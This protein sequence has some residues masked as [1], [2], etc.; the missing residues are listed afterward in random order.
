MGV[1]DDDEPA[2]IPPRQYYAQLEAEEELSQYKRQIDDELRLIEKKLELLRFQE[3]KTG[4]LPEEGDEAGGL[5]EDGFEEDGNDFLEEQGRLDSLEVER[6]LRQEAEADQEEREIYEAMCRDEAK[7]S[8]REQ[9][10]LSNIQRV[11][12]DF[13]H[14]DFEQDGNLFAASAQQKDSALQRE[15]FTRRLERAHDASPLSG[16]AKAAEAMLAA[17]ARS[18]LLSDTDRFLLDAL[19]KKFKK[20][21]SS[22]AAAPVA[23]AGHA[24]SE[25]RR[26]LTR[27]SSALCRTVSAE[28][29]ALVTELPLFFVCALNHVERVYRHHPARFRIVDGEMHDEKAML[30]HYRDS[31]G[32]PEQLHNDLQQLRAWRNR[33]MHPPHYTEGAGRHWRRAREESPTTRR[34]LHACS[35]A[36]GDVSPRRSYIY[37]PTIAEA[38]A[39]LES[40]CEQLEELGVQYSSPER[41]RSA[42]AGSLDSQTSLLLPRLERGGSS[43]SSAVSLLSPAALAAEQR[44]QK[45]EETES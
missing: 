28:E 41:T 33:S 30:E 24:M 11:L 35:N 6:R 37:R 2:P 45:R 15:A 22:T 21:T 23:A 34:R 36:L 16:P 4:A 25:K 10:E 13:E 32:L 43:M 40:I 7:R 44:R 39:L 12:E 27:L 5:F 42:P 20:T 31:C 14:E 19:D 1:S 8:R 3:W 9:Q 18:D 17:T 26:R 38:E 29:E